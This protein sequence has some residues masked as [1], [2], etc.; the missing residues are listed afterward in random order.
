MFCL[1]LCRIF[2]IPAFYLFGNKLLQL[3]FRH[4]CPPAIPWRIGIITFYFTLQK[5]RK[6]RFFLQIQCFST[7]LLYTST[8][9]A[10]APTKCK[11]F[12]RIILIERNSSF[13]LTCLKFQD[14]YKRQ[15]W[16]VS[17]TRLKA[18]P[19]NVTNS[20]LLK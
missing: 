14:V 4:G 12:S 10:R 13:S 3:F 16:M 11:L 15:S 5:F 17:T 20:P 18:N 19:R 7:C 1:N 8:Q 9:L 6:I 2:F